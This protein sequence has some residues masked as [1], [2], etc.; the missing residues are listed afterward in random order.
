[1]AQKNTR[2]FGNAQGKGSN[3]SVRDSIGKKRGSRGKTRI[4][5]GGK[6]PLGGPRSDRKKTS[7]KKSQEK[8][9]VERGTEK[10]KNAANP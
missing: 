4:G 9:F 7:Q 8:I 1:L 6:C 10:E 2:V 5:T 3:G